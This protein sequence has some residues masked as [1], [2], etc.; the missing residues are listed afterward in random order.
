[1]DHVRVAGLASGWDLSY[2]EEIEA[3]GFDLDEDAEE[4]GS[5]Q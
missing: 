2:F 3:E 5:N 1:M 4:L